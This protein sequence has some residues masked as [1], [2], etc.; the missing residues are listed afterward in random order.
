MVIASGRYGINKAGVEEKSPL[1]ESV[2]HEEEVEVIDLHRTFADKD[3]LLPDLVH[4]NTE[5]AGV[6]A[7]TVLPFVRS[8]SQ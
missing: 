8:V 4:P 7:R 3:A 2:A 5:G 1:I 6:I